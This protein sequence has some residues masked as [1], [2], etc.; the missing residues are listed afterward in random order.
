MQKFNFKRILRKILFLL[1]FSILYLAI[2][3]VAAILISNHFHYKLQDVLFIV[4]FLLFLLG[5]L[6]SMKG[7]PSG[8]SFSGIGQK[9]V[10][11]ISNLDLEV[12]RMEREINPYH[13]D[14]YK[15]N[16]VE[17]AF[18]NLTFLLGGV[19]IITSSILFF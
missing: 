13:K 15:N 9:N 12:T 11:A 19:L 1:I 10:N 2:G 3:Y 6:M 4:G 16:V 8:T 17:F 7:N 14:Y 5:I 18:G